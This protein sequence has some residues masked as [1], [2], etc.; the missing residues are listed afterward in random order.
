MLKILSITLLFC[1]NASA[2]N[3]AYINTNCPTDPTFNDKSSCYGAQGI[4]TARCKRKHLS[5]IYINH[6]YAESLSL[7]ALIFKTNEENEG[8]LSP[9]PFIIY[10]GAVSKHLHITR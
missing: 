8:K 2:W 4:N 7:D 10:N 6:E 3:P 9:Y 1:I 5:N